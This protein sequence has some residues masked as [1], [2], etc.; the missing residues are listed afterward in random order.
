MT[1]V[2]RLVAAA[3]LCGGCSLAFAQDL[4][5]RQTDGKFVTVIEDGAAAD[6]LHHVIERRNAD[7]S[8]DRYF[9]SGGRASFSLGTESLGPRSLRIDARGR[10]IVVGAAFGTSDRSAAAVARLLPNGRLD[11]GWGLRGTFL[12]ASPDGDIQGL[13][14]VAL[15]DEGLL[16]LGE[17]EVQGEKR[18]CL[19]R[20]RPDGGLD[21][22]FGRGGVLRAAPLDGS[23]AVSMHLDADGSVLI[24]SQKFRSG[25]LVLEVHRWRPGSD[26]LQP[27]A[28]Q[29]APAGSQGA[30]RLD[31]REGQWRWSVPGAAEA[32]PIATVDDGQSAVASM[33]LAAF[34][35]FAVQG[36]TATPLPVKEAVKGLNPAQGWMWLALSAALGVA[37]WRWRAARR[38][39]PGMPDSGEA[40]VGA[41]MADRFGVSG[42]SAPVGPPARDATVGGETM[43]T[44]CR[45][46]LPRPMFGPADDLQRIKGIGPVL[47]RRLNSE[48]IFYLWQIAQWR[49]EDE[50]TVGTGL[51]GFRG[52]IER[53]RWVAQAIELSK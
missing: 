39:E 2:L 9:G 10:L 23:Q 51:G 36:D 35:P 8:L 42:A 31:G 22:G 25:S 4:W 24:G 48:G 38:A 44:G 16:L 13:D 53:D 12:A 7:G 26:A 45:N 33:G 3:L 21:T 41:A 30:A 19:W 1:A 5:L 47:E 20:A 11:A 32:L 46:G 40:S 43:P 18:V 28:R 6:P 15:P 29:A 17:I 49:P 27:V 52:R 34:S 37:G 14:V 50:A